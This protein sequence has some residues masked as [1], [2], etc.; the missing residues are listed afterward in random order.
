MRRWRKRKEEGEKEDGED[1]NQGRRRWGE[2]GSKGE[3]DFALE[4]DIELKTEMGT[5]SDR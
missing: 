2:R 3:E 1:R 5:K 4:W